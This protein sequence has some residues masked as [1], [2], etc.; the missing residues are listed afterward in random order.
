MVHKCLSIAQMWIGHTRADPSVWC[1]PPPVLVYCYTR[2]CQ[3]HKCGSDAHVLICQCGVG[4]HKPSLHIG[5]QVSYKLQRQQTI[6]N[7]TSVLQTTIIDRCVFMCGNVSLAGIT[8]ASHRE[9]ASCM[10]VSPC[11]GQDWI[12]HGHVQTYSR[13]RWATTR[14]RHVGDTQAAL[15]DTFERERNVGDPQTLASAPD[16]GHE[17]IERAAPSL[18]LKYLHAYMHGHMHAHMHARRLCGLHEVVVF[19]GAAT[20]SQASK[21][22]CCGCL[23][24]RNEWTSAVG[25]VSGIV[26]DTT[27]LW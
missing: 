12:S 24:A 27:E 17:P 11:H 14:K 22:V 1:W 20:S 18:Q 13:K 9:H 23:L 8:T 7:I 16:V 2:A 21:R 25:G 26:R 5:S 19:V 4:H 3:L 15:G 10:C 6:V